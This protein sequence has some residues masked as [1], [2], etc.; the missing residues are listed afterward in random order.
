MVRDWQVVPCCALHPTPPP[1][2]LLPAPQESSNS[3]TETSRSTQQEVFFI[4]NT[5]A[6]G[7]VSE[8]KVFAAEAICRLVFMLVS[9]LDS[10]LNAKLEMAQISDWSVELLLE[11]LIR[12]PLENDQERVCKLFRRRSGSPSGR[13]RS[14]FNHYERA[15]R[16]R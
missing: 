5:L 15:S 6:A 2:L 8:G 10:T 4:A 16:S 12:G 1:L 9:E 14:L 11:P 7:Q 3:D 13:R